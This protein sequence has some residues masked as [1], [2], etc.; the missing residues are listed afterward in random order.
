MDNFYVYNLSSTEHKYKYKHLCTPKTRQMRIRLGVILDG[1]GIFNYVNQK[2]TVKKGDI[3]I[4]PE[5]IFCYS[6]WIGNPDIHVIYLNFNVNSEN[7]LNNYNLQVFSFENEIE[8]TEMIDNILKIHNTLNDTTQGQL[9]AY[10][11][12]YKLLSKLLPAMDSGR[13]KYK[14]ELCEAITFI[15]DN[16]NKD[17]K[18]SDV[19]KHCCSCEAKLYRLFKDE[20][21]QSPNDYLNSIKINYA[22]QYLE[23]AEY[24]VSEVSYMCNFHSESYFRKVFCKYMGITPSD[25]KK[26]FSNL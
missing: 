10:S 22:I 7:A 1:N 12:F 9:I 24:L 23:S 20:L 5:K 19:A 14:K 21:G 16:W 25:Y 3:V 13:K 17:F 11:E 15:T 18:F 26:Q 2:L 8:Q 6:E 4:I